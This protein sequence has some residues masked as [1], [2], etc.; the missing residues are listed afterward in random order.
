MSIR[1]R[2]ERLERDAKAGTDGDGLS[3]AE[4][5]ARINAI[6]EGAQARRGKPPL[7]L[8]WSLPEA[9]VLLR[10]AFHAA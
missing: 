9:V 5:L 1:S 8:Q 3:D 4:R 10:S 6:L 2:L 7:N